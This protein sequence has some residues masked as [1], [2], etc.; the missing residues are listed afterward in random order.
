VADQVAAEQVRVT[1]MYARLDAEVLALSSTRDG[2]AASSS[3]SDGPGVRSSAA[4]GS[5]AWPSTADEE[6]AAARLARKLADLRGAE[7]GLCFGRIDRTDGTILHIGRRG[8]WQA[9]EPLLV[10]WRA[11]AAAPFYAAT[12][13]HPMGLRRRRHLRL[14]GRTVQ[15]LS[16]E[17][18]DG[19]APRADDVLGDGP[20]AEALN[21]KRT[22]RM[23]D[24]VTTLQAEQDA[25]VRSPHRGVTVVQGGPGTGKTVV[26]LH[27][28]AYV[29][30]AFPAAADRGVLVVGPDARFLDYISQVLPS[31]GENDVRL[32]TR[33]GI[34]GPATEKE[35]LPVA[36]LKGRA[37]L[38]DGIAGWVRARR[39]AAVPITLPAGNDLIEISAAAV[40][41]AIAAAADL[42]HNPGRAAFKQHLIAEIVRVRTRAT[43]DQL[44]RIDAETAQLVGV[45]LDE[46]V[47][48]DLRSLGLA[49][50]PAGDSPAAGSATPESATASSSAAGLELD[51]PA[52]ARSALRHDQR[53][54]DAITTLWPPLTPAEAVAGLLAAPADHLPALAAGELALLWRTP[55]SPW[56]VADM[57]L[58]DEAAGLIDGP[59]DD[60]YGHVVVDEAQELTEMDWRVVMRRCPS[61]SMTVVG[62][63][64]QAG[65]GST[66][67]SW[68][69][70]LHPHVSDRFQV[71][72]LTIN[73]RTTA[74]ILDS[75]R[76]LLTA[77]A[78]DQQLSHSLRHGEPP[79]RRRSTAIVRTVLEE[80]DA[81]TATHPGDLIAV[82]CAD[83][84]AP[85]LT[86]TEI[87][88]RARVIPVSEARGLEFDSVLVIAPQ[89]IIAARPGGHRDLY[90][91]LTRATRRLCTITR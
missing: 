18:L 46:A 74:E 52:A 80:L 72:T 1:A 4:N 40:A 83:Q 68:H 78:P 34:A 61:H 39:P 6:A 33:S 48:A 32:A 54:D 19:S 49:G 38:A 75:T 63:I 41:D 44:E 27:R 53:L 76:D 67:T 90:V 21:A 62:D 36:R 13:A 88:D 65:P 37:E 35:S 71:H 47:A 51:D 84:A 55:G 70:A 60:V 10:D 5:A 23:R 14:A 58:L 16:D 15:G 82:I 50:P 20:L 64:A 81:Q 2:S 9:G 89:E 85:Q 79:H 8:L 73:Y 91:A 12:P 22:G 29:L 59:P 25:I 56:S 57:A 43:R 3:P 7:A 17:I 87:T 26:A 11:P 42:P 69:A 77:I 86:G 28:A 31:L 30:F 45:D 24:A 66:L